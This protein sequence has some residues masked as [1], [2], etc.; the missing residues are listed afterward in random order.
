MMTIHSLFSTP[1][2]QV[3]LQPDQSTFDG[4]LKYMRRFDANFSKR[5]VRSDV[6]VF[7]DSLPGLT[8]D[9]LH[10]FPEFQWLTEVLCEHVTEYLQSLS[11]VKAR[12]SIFVQ[13]SWPVVCH[14]SGGQVQPHTHRN[15]HLSAVYYIQ[16]D[17]QNK[18]GMIKF[19]APLDHY[20]RTLPIVFNDIDSS[21]SFEPLQGRLLLFPS[22]LMHY[23][24]Q[25]FGS[26]SRYSVS[27]DLMLSSP[28]D[29]SLEMVMS[30]PS[31]WRQL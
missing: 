25:Y 1:I 4:M 19:M 5:Q 6:G 8:T 2:Y 16:S 12:Y 27:Y 31:S 22:S 28:S 13:K 15:A 10:C 11:S 17:S 20:S 30:N 29:H 26:I 14:P 24:D 9:R 18:T 21:F 3:D 7:G 23:V